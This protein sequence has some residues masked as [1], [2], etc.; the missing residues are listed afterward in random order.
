MKCRESA[1]QRRAR[2]LP[3]HN[4]K[5]LLVRYM[6]PAIAVAL[7]GLAVYHVSRTGKPAPEVRPPITPATTPFERTV[8]GAGMI[9]AQTENISIGSALPGV[10]TEVKVKV[11]QQVRTGDPLFTLDDRQLRAQLEARQAE[12]QSAQA[13]LARLKAMPRPEEI[14]IREAA[15]RQAEANLAMQQDMYRRARVLR[16]RNAASE[17]E[18]IQRQQGVESAAAILEQAQADLA[19]LKSGAW[20]EDVAVAE[21]KVASAKALVDQMQVELDR[22]TVRA[23]VDGEILQVNVRPGE[24]VGAPP[25]QTLILMGN[26]RQLRVRVDIDEDDIPRFDPGGDAVALL[27]GNPQREFPLRFVRV[28]PYV[29]PKRSLTGENTERVDTRVLQVIYDIDSLGEQLYVG[30]QLDVF[31]RAADAKGATG[32]EGASITAQR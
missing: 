28:E 27:R 15:V 25:T 31:I 10:V 18:L 13:E 14:P 32:R 29:I 2:N 9:E 5:N 7:L 6:T 1:P 26:V 17:S 4:M 12:L 22:L 16:E 8:A 21:A 3:I 23:L 30:Q 24:F 19:L 20:K 11:G